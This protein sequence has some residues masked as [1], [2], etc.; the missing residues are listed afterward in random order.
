M[1]QLTKGEDQIMQLV[2]QRDGV[3]IRDLLEA[4]PVPKP[5]YNTV[6]TLVKILVKKGF[7]TSE[8]VGN[9]H[10]YRA[11]VRLEDY[12]EKYLVNIKE[13]YFNNSFPK[14]ITHFAQQENLTAEQVEELIQLIKAQQA[15][16]S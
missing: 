12:R 10:R 1:T 7:L 5:H 2:W 15:Q 14:M 9:T 11:A 4:M 6:A 16:K 8:L 13:Q 3:F